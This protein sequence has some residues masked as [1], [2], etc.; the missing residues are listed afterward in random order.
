MV[1]FR[2]GVIREALRV[3]R[4]WS[5]YVS[6]ASILHGLRSDDGGFVAPRVA[7]V[8]EHGR[9]FFVVEQ[10]TEGG[11]KRHSLGGVKFFANNANMPP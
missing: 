6:L 9:E 10:C 5:R 4:R 7:D 8:C 1:I 11:H 2:E 3:S